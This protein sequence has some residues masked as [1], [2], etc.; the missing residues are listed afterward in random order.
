MEN[1]DVSEKRPK[2]RIWKWLKITYFVGIHILAIFAFVMIGIAVAAKFKWTNDK[3]SIDVNN[4]YFAQMAN[5]YNQGF[6]LDSLNFESEERQMYQRVGLLAQHYPF[7]AKSILAAYQKSG[8]LLV[9][10]RMLDATNLLLKDNKNYQKKL[11]EIEN[12]KS[13]NSLSLYPWANYAEWKDFC[14]YV[15]AD[16]RAIDSVAKITGVESRLIVMCLVGEQIRMFNSSREKLKNQVYK[17]NHIFLPK[18]RGYGVTGILEHTA[19]RIENT[20]FTPSSP[21]YPG[22]YYRQCINLK[23][24]FPESVIDTIAAHKYPTIQRLIQGGNHFYS[25]L[26]TALLLRQ[27][28]SHWEKSGYTLA[29]RP[30]ILGTLFNLGYQKSKPGPNPQVGGSNFN[31]G[32]NEYTFGGLCF[33]FYYSGELQDLFP[34]TSHPFIPTEEL[35]RT[36]VFPDKDEEPTENEF[37]NSTESN[38]LRMMNQL[39]SL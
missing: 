17:Y 7:N 1:Q 16:K 20:L 22:D 36:I 10:M 33:E 39:D 37:L 4:R 25:Y 29:Y 3:G 27:Y 30:E 18:N 19:L 34:L 5:K 35:E 8:D 2:R 11:K 21:F 31:V 14:K 26:Y 9:A 6:K 15:K 23:D 12:Q 28:Q 13:D 32:D 24:S 38:G